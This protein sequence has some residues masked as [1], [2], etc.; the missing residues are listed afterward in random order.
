MLQLP[1]G[2]TRHSRSFTKAQIREMSRGAKVTVRAK[3]DPVVAAVVAAEE[4]FEKYLAA[5]KSEAAAIMK[6]DRADRGLAQVFPIDPLCRV[7]TG[8]VF[9]SEFQ[10]E[11]IFK[12]EIKTSRAVIAHRR[13]LMRD[14]RKKGGND[15][16]RYERMN[17]I[18]GQLRRIELLQKHKKAMK[19]AVRKEVR[20][21]TA[22]QNKVGLRKKRHLR[23]DAYN[24]ALK[25]HKVVCGL[26]PTTVH[27]AKML[28][29]FAERRLHE[30]HFDLFGQHSS[31]PTNW[32]AIIYRARA[33]L[34][35]SE[36]LEA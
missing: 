24:D 4:A 20:R 31:F 32:S 1:H 34:S 36:P 18:E 25:A 19:S 16:L 35:G 9:F 7:L 15:P 21:I 10:T 23:I 13:K 28:L 30:R 22:A 33:V 3:A 6:L 5:T 27:G 17:S 2:N 12:R 29:V 26:K 11:S 8:H 14:A